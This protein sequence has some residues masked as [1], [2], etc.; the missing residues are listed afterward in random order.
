MKDMQEKTIR[1]LLEKY[2]EGM[3]SIEDERAL[4]SYF[5]TSRYV[6][7]DLEY[8]REMFGFFTDALQS[9][10]MPTDSVSLGDII[11]ET[12]LKPTKKLRIRNKKILYWAASC[13]AVVMIAL[14]AGVSINRYVDH[15]N[16][17][18]YVNGELV[19][20]VQKQREVTMFT[21]GKAQESMEKSEQG[22]TVVMDQNLFEQALEMSMETIQQEGYFD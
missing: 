17:Y 7:S 16:Y 4:K 8:A 15:K 20:D 14:F 18:C 13:A 2:F 6:P 1:D 9:G 21:L 11:P 12:A 5:S 19:T 3:T 10:G 22:S